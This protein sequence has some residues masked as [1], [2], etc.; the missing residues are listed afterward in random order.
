MAL[1]VYTVRMG[2]TTG[3]MVEYRYVLIIRGELSVIST[4]MIMML[5]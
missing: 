3:D 5:V 2:V 4:G 1:F